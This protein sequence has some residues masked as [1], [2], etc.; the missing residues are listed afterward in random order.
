[1]SPIP[2][3]LTTKR[4]AEELSTSSGVA[5]SI[6]TEL[7][8]RPYPLGRGRGRGYRWKWSEVQAALEARRTRQFK[9]AA[10]NKPR[11]STAGRDFFKQPYSEALNEMDSLRD[12]PREERK[13]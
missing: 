12:G 3:Y 1:M 2:A 11:V 9:A 4:V 8:V 7:G 6:L 13:R 5:M 10:K